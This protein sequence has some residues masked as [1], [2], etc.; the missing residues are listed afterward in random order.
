LDEALRC[1]WPEPFAS[2]AIG[3]F[4]HTLD[5]GEPFHSPGSV[6]RRKDT[7][8]VE[9]Y[10]WKIE[11][12]TLPD[13]RLG[14]VCHFYDLS[15]RQRYE[16]ALRKSEATFRAMFDAS[17]VGKIE[18]EPGSSRFL[19]V[20]AAMCKFLGYSE[21]ELLA[22]T[23]LEITHPEDRDP[24]PRGGSTPGHRRVRCFRH[25]KALYP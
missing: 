25:R 23:L 12:V 9:S 1:I 22:R 5:S 19:R 4:R 16:A 6:E 15:E 11:R 14:V 24:Q 2:D 3:R 13:G 10:D 20:N 17:S 21:E 8:E 18:V 7:D